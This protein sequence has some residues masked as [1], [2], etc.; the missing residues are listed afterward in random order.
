MLI[1]RDHA[2]TLDLEKC[3]PDGL[4]MPELLVS[5]LKDK[6]IRHSVQILFCSSEKIHHC[7]SN[8]NGRSFHF[9]I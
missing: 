5:S 1:R 6:L 3:L 4:L 8:D 9:E 7:L 2:C